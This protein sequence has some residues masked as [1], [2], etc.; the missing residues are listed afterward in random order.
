MVAERVKVRVIPAQGVTVTPVSVAGLPVE[1]E[2]SGG[3]FLS[4]TTTQ[5][6]AFTVD[7]GPLSAEEERDL[8]L[9]VQVPTAPMVCDLIVSAPP[10]TLSVGRLV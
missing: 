8:M 10:T 5:T 3:G 9:T 1:Y 7:Y 6:G 4:G 2:T